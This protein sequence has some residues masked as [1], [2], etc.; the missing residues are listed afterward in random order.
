MPPTKTDPFRDLLLLQERMSR[1]FDEALLK[2]RAGGGLTGGSWYPP[3]DIYETEENIILKAELPGVDPGSVS[4][5]VHDN[6]LS[7]KGERKLQKG[8]ADENY[9]RMERF[10]GAFNRAFSLPYQVDSNSIKASF[11][12]GILKISIPK[13]REAAASGIKVR[14]Q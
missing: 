12:D 9:Y 4:V 11:A 2:Y 8:V 7:L 6:T 10:Y 5:E 13:R 1:I 14:V 3:V